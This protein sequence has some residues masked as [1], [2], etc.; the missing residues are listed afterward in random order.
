[1]SGIDDTFPPYIISEAFLNAVVAITVDEHL[2]SE[3]CSLKNVYLS[4]TYSIALTIARVVEIAQAYL[5][6]RSDTR[7]PHPSVY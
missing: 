5:I 2:S 4:P 6:Y 7:D 3:A 1:M